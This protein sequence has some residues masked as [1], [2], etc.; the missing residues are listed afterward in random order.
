MLV[1][2]GSKT[3]DPADA[4]CTSG[5][6]TARRMHVPPGLSYLAS[7]TP[8]RIADRRNGEGQRK[9]GIGRNERKEQAKRQM[10]SLWRTVF[11]GAWMIGWPGMGENGGNEPA[12][13]RTQRTQRCRDGVFPFLRRSAAEPALA[14]QTCSRADVQADPSFPGIRF[15]GELAA[16]RQSTTALAQRPPAHPAHQHSTTQVAHIAPFLPAALCNHGAML[17]TL[18]QVPWSTYCIVS[19]PD[20]YEA[21]DNSAYS[22]SALA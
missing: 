12:P 6:T 22:R 10:S 18:G 20:S 7:S 8:T 4:C 5:G 16:P 3:D 2:N 1:C 9:A 14:R 11:D 19:G 13:Q 15:R 21:K 17:R